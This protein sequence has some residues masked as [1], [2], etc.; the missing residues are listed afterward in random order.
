MNLTLY[1]KSVLD[2]AMGQSVQE[3]VME[4]FDW[5]CAG[6]TLE[7]LMRSYPLKPSK[8]RR[9]FVAQG[10]N[11][12]ERIVFVPPRIQPILPVYETA[13]DYLDNLPLELTEHLVLLARS[14]H[15][16]LGVGTV[17]GLRDVKVVR[18]Y[19]VRKG[20]GTAQDTLDSKK[21]VSSGGSQLRRRETTRFFQEIS[22]ELHLRSEQLKACRHLFVAT[23]VRLWP[24]IFDAK[25][26]PPFMP[27]DERVM[28]M[29]LDIK[30]PNREGLETF[31]EQ[32]GR[33][34]WAIESPS[35]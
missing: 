9:R 7:S 31:N 35:F 22:K 19:M 16:A 26:R 12:D 23:P 32:L 30:T 28:K 20:Q 27:E 13:Q 24:Q 11:R 18:R 8:N 21:K 25:P 29:A 5:R 1:E 6:I 3:M 10:D 2:F 14:G 17:D 15:A 4:R 34:Y 33:G